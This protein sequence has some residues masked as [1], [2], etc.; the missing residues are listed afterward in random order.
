MSLSSLAYAIRKSEELNFSTVNFKHLDILN[1]RNIKKTFDIVEVMG[2]LH[3]M[4][5]PMLGLETILGNINPGGLLRIGLYSK[6]A[7]ENISRIRKDILELNIQANKSSML[8]FRNKIKGSEINCYE[9]IFLSSDAYSSS[10]F[11]DLIFHEHELYFDLEDIKNFIKKYDLHFCGFDDEE[12]NSRFQNI[13]GFSELQNLD[14]WIIIENNNEKTFS[15]MYQFWCQ[16][17]S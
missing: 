12:L 2:V 16:K 7:R 6:K 3:H 13:Y 15:K 5:D 1:L 8:S 17:I 10:G 9:E 11:R 4:E 14:K